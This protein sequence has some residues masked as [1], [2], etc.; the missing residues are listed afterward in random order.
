MCTTSGVENRSQ[1]RTQVFHV[2]GGQHHDVTTIFYCDVTLAEREEAPPS[3][4][5]EAEAKLQAQRR[6]RAGVDVRERKGNKK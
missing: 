2:I 5:G 6:L 3:G 1:R 4:G